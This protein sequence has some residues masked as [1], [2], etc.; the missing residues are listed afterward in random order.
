V[1]AATAASFTRRG[2]TVVEAPFAQISGVHGAQGDAVIAADMGIVECLVDGD[3]EA[4]LLAAGI[5]RMHA[6]GWQVRILVPA[7]GAG[8]MH[9]V[10]R[11]APAL[12]Q[13]WWL[14]PEDD[15]CFGVPEVP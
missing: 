11:G 7:G 12:I 8:E 5:H 2:C 14:G 10:L 15:I 13:P 6:D 4:S 3:F 9:R 1:A